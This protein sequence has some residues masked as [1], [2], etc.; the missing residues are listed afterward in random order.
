MLRMFLTAACAVVLVAC[1]GGRSGPSASAPAASA[2]ASAA[3]LIVSAEDVLTL[4]P[5][6]RTSGPVI[7]GSIQPERR[8]D[9]RA[10]VS[11]VVMQV[12]KDNGDAVR[13]GDLLLRLDDAAIR[14]NL[15]SAQEA[16]R[17][18][19]RAFEQAE[20]TAQRLRTLQAQGMTSLQA[21]EDAEVRR[22]NAQSDLLAARARTA[23]ARQQ[24][25]RTEVRAPFDGIVSERKA[26]VGDTAQV[27]RE[28]LKVIDPRSMRL[29]GLVSA[30]RIA[31]VRAG[32]K[33]RFR[34][35]GYPGVEFSGE[36]RRV[37]ASAN[38][39]TRQLAVLVALTGAETPKVAGLFAEGR[40]ETAQTPAIMVAEASLV[41]DGDRAFVWKLDGQALRKAPVRLGERDD[42]SGE[43]VVREGLAAGERILRRPSATLVDGRAFQWGGAAAGASAPRS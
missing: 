25:Q 27:G 10:E 33:V 1:G 37:D 8:A 15:A 34:V 24:L 43:V 3:P 29:E 5:G 42:R 35:N 40:I 26:S 21:M 6:S 18:S 7:A 4:T 12:L 19:Q 14:D 13:R 9:L 2:A 28:L 22:N 17:A 32:Q 30:D 38:A 16:E 39:A 11:A 41:R 31:E 23:T 20:R 36:V